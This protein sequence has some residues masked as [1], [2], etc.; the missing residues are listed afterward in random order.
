MH[1]KQRPAG[2]LLKKYT[3]LSRIGFQS[4]AKS[5]QSWECVQHDMVLTI[6][7]CSNDFIRVVYAIPRGLNFAYRPHPK[8]SSPFF[9]RDFDMWD[10]NMDSLSSESLVHHQFER[11][12]GQSIVIRMKENYSPAEGIESMKAEGIIF[13]ARPSKSDSSSLTELLV[14]A[15]P[16]WEVLPLEDSTYLHSTRKPI[17]EYNKAIKNKISNKETDELLDPEWIAIKNNILTI[18]NDVTELKHPEQA[19]KTLN[20]YIELINT[21]KDS[22]KD[23]SLLSSILNTLSFANGKKGNIIEKYNFN[24]RTKGIVQKTNNRSAVR[25]DVEWPAIICC[26]KIMKAT[27]SENKKISRFECSECHSYV[28][29]ATNIEA[30]YRFTSPKSTYDPISKQQN[31]DNVAKAWG[32]GVHNEWTGMYANL[33]RIILDKQ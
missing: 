29:A 16:C 27:T 15:S 5:R 12:T 19:L 21:Y 4:G 10:K 33:A 20:A 14:A 22:A 1:I 30:I 31:L 26:S 25:P 24:E 2:A 3:D 28:T 11:L 7:D 32:E 9:E 6:T 8:E 17:I 13:T 23:P 18:Y